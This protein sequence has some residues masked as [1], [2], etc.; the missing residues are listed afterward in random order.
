MAGD[1]H[2]DVPAEATLGRHVHG[3]AH[4][5]PDVTGPLAGVERLLRGPVAEGAEHL[6]PGEGVGV[7]RTELA[8]HEGPEL[9]HPHPAQSTDVRAAHRRHAVGGPG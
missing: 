1:L 7:P 3:V 2:L 5:V 8:L 6:V 9:T 4:R